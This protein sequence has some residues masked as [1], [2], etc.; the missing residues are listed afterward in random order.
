M[1]FRR[2]YK[3]ARKWYGKNIK[4]QIFLFVISRFLNLCVQKQANLMWMLLW[5]TVKMPED[6]FIY[7]VYLYL[8]KC[9]DEP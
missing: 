1:H 2:R 9:L 3:A 8:C 7:P 6:R 5:T 4:R